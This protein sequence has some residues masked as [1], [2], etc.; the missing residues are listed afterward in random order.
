[1]RN[2]INLDNTSKQEINGNG[3]LFDDRQQQ[4]QRALKQKDLMKFNNLEQQ[5]VSDKKNLIKE[6]IKNR[7][8]V[9]LFDGYENDTTPKQSNK[10][11]MLN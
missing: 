2:S 4:K 7:I 1:M 5:F 10:Q 11:D 3:F 6:E 8:N 9:R